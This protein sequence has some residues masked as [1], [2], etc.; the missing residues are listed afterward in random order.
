MKWRIVIN[1]FF[2]GGLLCLEGDTMGACGSMP[3]VDEVTLVEDYQTGTTVLDSI[4]NRTICDDLEVR[5]GN[6]GKA[7]REK[8]S[9]LGW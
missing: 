5:W 1:G 7:L 2:E 6:G 3:L 8:V 9:Q 4:L